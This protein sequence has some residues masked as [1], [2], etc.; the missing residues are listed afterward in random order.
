M[1]ERLTAAERAADAGDGS[2]RRR[3][4]RRPDRPRPSAGTAPR[5]LR[6]AQRARFLRRRLHRRPEGRPLARHHREGPADPR[7]PDA[8]RRGRR[9]PAGRRRRRHAGPD[10][11]RIL[12]GGMRRARLRA[13][14]APATTASAIS[15]C[16][17]TRRCA[18]T[19]RR[20]SSASSPRRARR[21]SAG[22]RVPTDNSSPV[23]EPDDQGERAVPPAGLHRPRREDRGGRRLRAPALHPPQGDL[24]RHPSR[25]R[26]ASTAASTSCRCRRGR[27]ST[28]ACS[29]PTSSAPTIRTCTI[30]ASPRRWRW[31]ISASRPTRSRRGSS[32]TPTGWSRITA[33][34]TRCAAT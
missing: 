3:Q 8:P 21:S 30:R 5:P 24:Q 15:S 10:P 26:R 2:A 7:E 29:S 34:S 19:T 27:S 9:R 20:S 25:R 31:C 18:R 1:S 6:S 23:A 28:R 14:R 32:R 17:A 33:R 13:A 11:A 4:T 12:R 22:A 16:R